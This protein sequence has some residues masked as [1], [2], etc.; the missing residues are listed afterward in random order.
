MYAI[1]LSIR[2]LY[3]TGGKAIKKKKQSTRNPQAL[4]PARDN[5]ISHSSQFK[6]TKRR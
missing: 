4:I 3:V 6:I 5:S 2:G 1:L